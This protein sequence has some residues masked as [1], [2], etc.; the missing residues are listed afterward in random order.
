MSLVAKVIGV[1]F[2]AL[3]IGLCLYIAAG[4]LEGSGR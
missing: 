4:G 1:A 3:L 2:W